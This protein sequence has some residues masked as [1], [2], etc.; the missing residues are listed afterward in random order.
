M[1][2]LPTMVVQLV[3]IQGPL[4]GQ[5]QEFTEPRITIGRHPSCAVRFPT[6]LTGISRNHAE[7]VQEGNR[8]K[9]VD[10]STNG[11]FVNGKQVKESFL[12]DGDVIMFSPD[13]PKVSFLAQIS[14]VV[15]PD[16]PEGAAPMEQVVQDEQMAQEVQEVHDAQE[17]PV[18]E[19]PVRPVPPQRPARKQAAPGPPGRQAPPVSPPP[20]Q[21]TPRQEVPVQK[22]QVPLI[23]QYGPTLN[24]FK[25]LPV[26]L[27]QGP[28]NTLVIAH[29][30][31]MDRHAQIF[32]AQGQYWIKDLT[33]KKSVAIN[34]RPIDLQAAMNPHDVL[35]LGP[36]GPKFRF[37]GEG[38]LAEYEE[39]PAEAAPEPAPQV[40]PAAASPKKAKSAKSIFDI[41]KK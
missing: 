29:P 41:F 7:L 30:G 32:F 23:V 4:M 17:V 12:K 34:G 15:R 3:H 24:S 28:G 1:N 25:E 16:V 40:K 37:L 2:N 20:A 39:P 9:L 33:G 18:E 21:S 6:D 5:I 13:G 22:V 26:N 35:S 14:D 19:P 27:G 8:F 31:I 36:Q 11:T 10:R 38:R